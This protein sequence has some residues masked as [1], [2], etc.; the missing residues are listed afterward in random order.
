MTTAR[1]LIDKHL[2]TDIEESSEAILQFKQGEDFTVRV[3]SLNHRH[4]VS[5][6]LEVQEGP[7]KGK[8]LL[9]SRVFA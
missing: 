7:H 1:E 8:L 6:S 5:A 9:V 2:G 4:P 3:A